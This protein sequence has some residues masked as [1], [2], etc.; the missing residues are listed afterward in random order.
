MEELKQIAKRR[1]QLGLKQTQLAKLAGVSQSLIAKVERSI[2]DI[3]YSKAQKIFNALD[4]EERKEEVSAKDIMTKGVKG[5]KEA[6]KLSKA[7]DLMKKL[8]ISQIP[9]F[10]GEVCV[11]SISEEGILN[12]IQEGVS[13][14]SL[15]S[16]SSNERIE[17]SFPTISKNAD[18]NEITSLLQRNKAILVAEKG[19]IIGIITKADLLKAIKSH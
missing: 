15:E 5:I 11:G 16:M 4:K 12:A 18:L 19:E 3:A 8:R 7:F 1:R 17:E 6:D 9:V 10:K 2:I 14:K 13:L